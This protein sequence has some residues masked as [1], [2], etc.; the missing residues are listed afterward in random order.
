MSILQAA[1]RRYATKVFDPTKKVSDSDFEILKQIV[2]LSPSSINI[3][4]WHI[5]IAKTDEA[6]KRITKATQN[7]FSF[8]EH[9]VLDASHVMVFCVKNNIG[10]EQ[11]EKLLSQEAKDGR[12]ATPEIIATNRKFRQSFIDLNAENPE[13]LRRWTEKQLYIALGNVLLAAGSLGIDSVPI[14]GF[15]AQILDEELAL[16]E[17]GLSSVVMVSFGY[18]S[19]ADFN[20]K[21]AKSRFDDIFTEI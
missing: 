10:S 15:D 8:N 20:F 1:K 14:E 12:L 7:E 21:L 17:Q 3:Q 6:K 2:Q 18:H 13:K 16:A 9:K 19:E 5:L 11:L 4:P